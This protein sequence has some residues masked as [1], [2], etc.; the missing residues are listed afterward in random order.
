MVEL[1]SLKKSRYSSYNTGIGKK[2]VGGKTSLEE[3]EEYTIKNGEV[4]M[5][6]G[7]QEYL[8]SVLNNILFK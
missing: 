5:E 2:I 3:L 4:T 8:E 7:K 6:S 1:M